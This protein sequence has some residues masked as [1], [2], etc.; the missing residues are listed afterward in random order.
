MK[1]NID[2][3]SRRDFLKKSAAIGAF[4][5]VPGYVLGGAKHIAPSDK[6]TIGFIGCGKLSHGLSRRFL[7]LEGVKIT[8]NCDVDSQKLQAYADL[9][10][11]IY[12]EKSNQAG[13]QGVDSYSN[14]QDLLKRDDIDAV[15][16]ATPDHWHALI[17]I[18]A[19][20]AGKDV[21]CE[22][23]L[24]HTVYE[25]RKMVEAAERNGRIL[26]TGSM[27][28][29]WENFRRA[30]ELV[31]NGM[32]GDI[33]TVKVSIGDPAIHCHLPAEEEPHYLDWNMW[34]GPAQVRPYN[35]T[36]SPPVSFTG[37]PDWRKYWPFGGGGIAD[38]GA[39]M[40]DIA[41]WGLGMDES[42]PVELNPPEERNAVRGLRFRYA[43]G[44]EM[45]HEDFG[46]GNAVEFTGSEGVIRVSRQFLE[47][48][49]E[50]ILSAEIPENGVHLY[51]SNNHYQNW[52]DC[53]HS[54]ERPICDAETGHRSAT[55]CN[56]ANIAYELKKP[57][58]WDP[59]NE[60]FENEYVANTL[61][62]RNY[63]RPFRL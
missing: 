7:E 46:R 6:V 12:A 39:H 22:K 42:G 48:E 3:S 14:Y 21:Y 10:N 20:N 15:I 50:K 55:V 35:S 8:A 33:K 38:W 5:I 32:I 52:I 47:A 13:Y 63:R 25:G 49:P 31:R 56:I 23:P 62:T 57:L 45:V 1:K 41:Q 11:G 9:V 53:I 60:R 27:Q 2:P 28:R 29:S 37:W 44:V 19:I 26:Q 30:C 54:R 16:V 51:H 61:L 43:N 58:K 40:F 17:S 4:S 36:L 18:D 24:A 59:V 34:L